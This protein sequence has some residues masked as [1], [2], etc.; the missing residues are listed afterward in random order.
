MRSHSSVLAR[1]FAVVV[2]LSLAGCATVGDAV[3]TGLEATLSG[4]EEVPGPGDPDGSGS[5]EITIVDRTDNLCYEVTVRNIAPATAAHIHRGAPGR[6]GPP[7]VTL[8]APTD[9]ESNACLSVASELVDEIEANPGNFY[10][11]VHNAAFPNGAVRGQ[12]AR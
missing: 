8:D 3:G 9:G 5:A 7:V 11:N 2:G 6:A 12:L 10:I 4:A 1:S